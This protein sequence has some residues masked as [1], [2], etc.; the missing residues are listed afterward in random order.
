[1]FSCGIV[2]NIS[3]AER[4]SSNTRTVHRHTMENDR[5][6]GTTSSPAH[7]STGNSVRMAQHICDSCSRGNAKRS[8]GRAIIRRRLLSS[9]SASGFAGVPR[10]FVV[11]GVVVVVVMSSCIP[12]TGNNAAAAVCGYVDALTTSFSTQRARRTRSHYFT[13]RPC[14]HSHH[15]AG[16]TP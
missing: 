7:L 15:T 9:L 16:S 8:R 14:S 12:Y 3:I 10:V 1:M 5:K 11:F 2:Y 4:P 13:P 6:S